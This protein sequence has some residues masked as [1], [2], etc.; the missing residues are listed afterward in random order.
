[1]L[2]EGPRVKLLTMFEKALDFFVC[3]IFSFG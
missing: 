1:M 2:Y 3:F